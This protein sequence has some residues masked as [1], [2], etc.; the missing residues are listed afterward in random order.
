[1]S[2]YP[3]YRFGLLLSVLL[4][5]QHAPAAGPEDAVVAVTAYASD[6]GRRG[7]GFVV[8]SSGEI[9][10][11]YHTVV[12]ALRIE[13]EVGNRS[14]QASVERL[15]PAHDL[16]SLR[17][18]LPPGASQLQLF[19]PDAQQLFGQ[20]LEIIGHGV[21]LR[22]LVIQARM[23]QKG[24]VGS[25]Q[26]RISGERLFSAGSKLLML[27]AAAVHDGMS[28]GPVLFSDRVVAVLCGS[29]STG[30]DL[31]WGMDVRE[32]L[33]TP[34]S[35]MQSP[36]ANW[37]PFRL[38][39]TSQWRTLL[40]SVSLRDAHGAALTRYLSDWQASREAYIA[41]IGEMG[42]LR[43]KVRQSRMVAG[44]GS[45][46][47][48]LLDEQTQA[49]VG[50]LERVEAAQHGFRQADKLVF[51]AWQEVYD[52]VW[53]IIMNMPKTQENLAASDEYVKTVLPVL[54]AGLT[55][56]PEV[57][58]KQREKSERVEKHIE[59]ITA[60]LRN[61]SRRLPALLDELEPL[62]ASYWDQAIR[63][64][65]GDLKQRRLT[66]AAGKLLFLDV[67]HKPWVFR[68]KNFELTFPAGWALVRAK[69]LQPPSSEA[70]R[71]FEESYAQQGV[72]I[73]AMAGTRS[74][75]GLRLV[76]GEV[77]NCGSPQGFRPFDI[78]GARAWYG[79]LPQVQN[80]S[81][82]AVYACRTQG[83]YYFECAI[84]TTK[85]ADWTNACL[86]VV[87]SL[88]LR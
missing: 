26:L 75:P 18:D 23:A 57:L 10:T 63:V 87:R 15:A 51:T 37:P 41:Y 7:T 1:M 25:E 12:G 52:N 49:I 4:L 67:G 62:V 42:Q 47:N 21:G 16:A 74:Y 43:H 85:P 69:D 55:E 40:R 73:L 13:V 77:A 80:E 9:V 83:G 71:R 70:I 86:A 68:G 30:G 36:M 46:P 11:C 27:Q 82:S 84:P 88:R 20:D 29:V 53:D 58:A 35:R 28:G 33:S 19:E 17:I 14:Y 64:G 60:E 81:R 76:V 34:I 79:D 8:A 5:S 78:K 50:A 38:L 39:R 48:W 31:A 24:W 44:G 61:S 54:Q 66:A 65:E 45:L 56:T 72:P 2:Q 3:Q 6:A 59:A 32:L 22:H